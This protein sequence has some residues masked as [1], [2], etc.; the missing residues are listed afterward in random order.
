M[1][2]AGAFANRNRH[3]T[4]R[5]CAGD[6]HVFSDEIEGER[7]VH[8]VAQRIE[9]GKH[10]LRNRRVG[11]PAV[12]LRDRHELRPSTGTINTDALSAI[13]GAG[14]FGQTASSIP[15]T[16]I[17]DYLS[18][19]SG[20]QGAQSLG[21]QASQNQF[22]QQQTGFLDNQLLGRG[23]GQGLAQI[24]QGWGKAFPNGFNF[25]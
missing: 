20:G 11:M 15:Q 13:S 10:I 2:R 3:A 23:L 14:G 7:C 5:A 6:E 16:Q 18:Y 12:L 17:Q 8:G 1:T 9:T 21:L 4:D 19:L 25:G 24:G 22:N